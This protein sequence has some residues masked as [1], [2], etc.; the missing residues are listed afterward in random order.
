MSAAWYLLSEGQQLGPY[1]GEQL[2]QFVQEGRVAAETMVWA[3][4]MAEWQAAAQIPG[5][6]PATQN[7]AAKPA[8]ATSNWAPPGAR[9]AGNAAVTGNVSPYSTPGSSLASAPV[10]G[11]YPYLSIKPA[12]FALWMWTFIG[13]F[14]CL[15]LMVVFF[16]LGATSTSSSG[17]A[18]GGAV[19]V[20][21][22]LVMYGLCLICM[23]LSGIFFYINLYRAWSCL[24][25]G[26]PRTSPGKAI[27]LL[28][29]PFF[30]LYWLF[31]A[32]AGLP[33][34]WNRIVASYDDLTNAPRLSESVFLMFCIGSLVFP[35]L[36]LIVMFPMMS[37]ICQGINFFAYRRNQTGSSAFGGIKFG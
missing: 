14:I 17:N 33:K 24:S 18:D 1:T 10:G 15:A 28:F 25:S 4:G 27:G 31:V 8:L 19:G 20:L 12:S 11:S 5:L 23:L 30:N 3:E 37:Q 21:G 9:A 22:G 26:A 13:G 32:I 35:P 16:V 36:S 6:F 34:D 2:Q 29:V 7:V